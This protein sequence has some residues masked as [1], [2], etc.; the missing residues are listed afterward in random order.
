M[1]LGKIKLPRPGWRR[2]RSR[3]GAQST[4]AAVGLEPRSRCPRRARWQHALG[5]PALSRGWTAEKQENGLPSLR[6]LLECQP[7]AGTSK[8]SQGSEAPKPDLCPWTAW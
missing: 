6:D 5:F 2:G 1:S 7:W 4:A 3:R 8:S